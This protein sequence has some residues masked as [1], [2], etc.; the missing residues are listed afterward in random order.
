MHT[1][2]VHCTGLF[3]IYLQRGYLYWLDGQP[4]RD[5]FLSTCFLL[6]K[7]IRNPLPGG[8]GLGGSHVTEL[9][10]STAEISSTLREVVIFNNI[11]R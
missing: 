5:K 8:R 2:S 3:S 9:S 4:I 10:D 7:N 6:L 11:A 1:V